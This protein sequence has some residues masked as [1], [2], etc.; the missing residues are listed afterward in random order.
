MNSVYFNRT[1]RWWLPPLLIMF[2]SV[3]GLGASDA[4]LHGWEADGAYNQ[5][6]DPG[7]RIRIK[8]E[9]FGIKEIIPMPGMAPGI[10]L[11][12]VTSEGERVMAHLGPKWFCPVSTLKVKSGERVRLYGVWAHIGQERVF[13]AAKLKKGDFYEIK[14][15]LTKNGQPFWTMT[16]EQLARELAEP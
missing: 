4:V 5:L 11:D 9:V 3:L 8:G 6:Y 12:I 14:F 2:S 16:P 13:L 1:I 15:R 7:R 10:A